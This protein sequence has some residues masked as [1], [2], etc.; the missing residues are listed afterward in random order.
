MG[1]KIIVDVSGYQPATVAYFSKLKAHGVYGVII[2]LTEGS[3]P[4]TAYLNPN[5]KLQYI[6]AR[7]A[8]LKVCGFYHYARFV[9]NSDAVNEASWFIRGLNSIGVK[10]KGYVMVCDAEDVALNSSKG[11]LTSDINAFLNHLKNKGYTKVDTYS[12]AYFLKSR[13]YINRL[14]SKNLWIAS[15]GTASAGILCGTWQFTD[16]YRGLKVDASLDYSGYYSGV[17]EKVAS[18]KPE[19]YNW[20]PNMVTS[21]SKINLYKTPE[22]NKKAGILS[23]PKGT[24]FKI[25]ALVKSKA[26]TPRFKTKSG[27]YIT[28]NKAVVKNSYYVDLVRQIKTL[29]TIWIYKDPRRTKRAKRGKFSKGTYFNIKKILDIGNGITSFETESGYWITTNKKYVV[30]TA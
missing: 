29:K 5:A 8:G 14:V 30:K 10:G 17:S 16:N 7:K 27:F 24:D 2:K 22:L 23:Y 4:G 13:T 6:N 20:K 11:G 21:I 15:Y 12:G 1:A 28:A 3:N 19:Y 26:G 9:G 25:S 18:S